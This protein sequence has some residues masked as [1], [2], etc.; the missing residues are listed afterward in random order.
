M[1]LV[2]L[3]AWRWRVGPMRIS[4][5]NRSC[6]SLQACPAPERD[7]VSLHVVRKNYKINRTLF[8]ESKEMQQNLICDFHALVP[9]FYR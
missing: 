8:A 3:H 6:H 2:L 7:V 4:Q 5:P 9:D 1:G